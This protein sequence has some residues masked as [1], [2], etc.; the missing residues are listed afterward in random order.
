MSRLLAMGIGKRF[1]PNEPEGCETPAIEREDFFYKVGIIFD[2]VA[3]YREFNPNPNLPY[4][5]DKRPKT[6]IE[7]HSGKEIMIVMPFE[8]F[9]GAYFKYYTEKTIMIRPN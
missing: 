9:D 7:L 2:N 5:Q 6:Q 3:D 4:Y 1:I 8:V